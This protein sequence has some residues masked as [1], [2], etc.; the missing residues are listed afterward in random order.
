MY[1]S[2]AAL[3]ARVAPL[4]FQN[5]LILAEG[6]VD[7]IRRLQKEIDDYLAVAQVPLDDL[8]DSEPSAGANP[9]R[10][11]TLPLRCALRPQRRAPLPPRVL[12]AECFGNSPAG[13]V[14]THRILQP[15]N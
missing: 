5:Y 11:S 3:H 15:T 10:G 7:H 14:P 4:N 9:R 1:K 8:P 2:L 6:P 12:P 13:R